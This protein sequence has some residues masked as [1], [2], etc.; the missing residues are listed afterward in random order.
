[1]TTNVDEGSLADLLDQP[2][3]KAK[4]N[5]LVNIAGVVKEAFDDLKS[6]VN[7]AV[8]QLRHVFQIP[9]AYLASDVFAIRQKLYGDSSVTLVWCFNGANL[10]SCHAISSQ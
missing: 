6:G 2:M 3:R 8:Y 7:C 9:Y 10:D 4:P 1:M 5:A